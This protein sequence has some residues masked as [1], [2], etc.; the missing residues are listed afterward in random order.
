MRNTTVLDALG[1]WSRRRP[2]S[3]ALQDP[4]RSLTR[5]ELAAAQ[6]AAAAALVE[7]GVRPGDRV[8]VLGPLS[9]DWAVAA[10]GVLRAGAVLCP[11]NERL[12]A[13]ELAE[14]LR[15][16]DPVLVVADDGHR[17]TLDGIDA[18]TP[19]VRSLAA[20]QERPAAGRSV[21]PDLPRDPTQPACILPTSGSTGRPKGVVYT[22]EAL[23]GAFFEW[24]LQAPELLRGRAL[25]VSAFSFAAGLLNGLLGPLVL[26]G[27][28]VL[29]PRWDAATAL[30]LIR[31][32]QITTFAATTI[33]YEQMARL[34]EF[35]DADLSSLTVAFTGGNPVTTELIEAWAAKGVGLRQAYGLTESLSNVTFPTVEMSVRSP[36]SV[37]EGG[38]LTRVVVTD[39]DGVVLPPG[40][41]GEIRISGPGLAAGYWQ[42]EEHT[43][44]AFADGWLR[45]GDVGV[46]DDHGALRVVGRL[47]DMIIS[48]GM[49]VYA[50]EVERAAL[51]LPGVVEVAVIGVPDDEFGET[52][53][54]L[55]RATEPFSD[56]AV[57]EHCRTRLAAYKMPRYVVFLD[58]PLPRTPSMKID[59]AAVR[60]RHTDIPATHRRHARTPL[61]A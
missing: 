47:K 58:E 34:P 12:G 5:R 53:A 9:V 52:P 50:A 44:E 38:I 4:A 39:P 45:T 60:D 27:S 7:A 23:L 55:L 10:L 3:P 17:P 1:A 31:D 16:I 28:V 26:G 51:A 46:V 48:G 57:L 37:G 24:A 21:L 13:F 18:D 29:L 49:N 42:D 11:L 36:E 2:D 32:E 61:P 40:E 22:H 43:A 30:R 20:M 54:L 19:A 14:V 25:G 56:Q 8:G 33:F 35:A 59:K 6:D 15:R 41:P